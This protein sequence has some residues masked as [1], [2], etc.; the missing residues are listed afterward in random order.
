MPPV[1]RYA[2]FGSE[3]VYGTAVAAEFHVDIQSATLD[4]PSGTEN[5][6]AGG[7]GRGVRTRRPGYYMPGGNIVY[8]WDIRTI[9]AML[10][11]TLGGYVFTDGD[12]GL[13]THEIYAS[14]DVILPSFTSRIGK[15][16]FEHVF[17]GC[18][19]DSLELDLA[20]DFLLATMVVGAKK[21][22]KAA[23]QA[24]SALLL[25]EEFPL[26]FHEA[27]MTLFGTGRSA[28]V[29]T[30]KLN[31]ANNQRGDSG[32]GIGSR[33]PYRMPVGNRDITLATDLWYDDTGDVEDFWGD[34]AGPADAGPADDAIVI[35]VS[36]GA[37]GAVALNLPRAHFTKVAT[38]PSGREEITASA[39]IR[40]MV[41]E[42]TLD[43]AVT[44]V[45]SELLATVTSAADDLVP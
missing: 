1:L 19:V 23:L 9:A 2:G 26:A 28:D 33:Y 37:D 31:I 44:T 24:E 32:R 17:A 22:S 25:P 41:D 40:A 38:Q 30:L 14:D 13:N 15:D 16:V 8:A 34:A 6:Y 36:A 20:G 42:I 39:E 29:K 27:T 5:Y 35:N 4:A 18:V 7:I 10:R 43:D 3:A 12:P 11:W 21:D 45:K